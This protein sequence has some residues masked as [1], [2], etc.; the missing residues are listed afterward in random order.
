MPRSATPSPGIGRPLADMREVVDRLDAKLDA[1]AE[2]PRGIA[3]LKREVAAIRRILDDRRRTGGRTGGVSTPATSGRI[4]RYRLCAPR[5]APRRGQGEG[6]MADN[7]PIEWTDASWNPVRARNLETGKVGWFCTHASDG[8]RFCYAETF[9]RRLGTGIDYRAQDRDKVEI[10]LD[11][12]TLQQ[13]LHWR[14]P[15]RIFT[16]SMSDLFGEFIDDEW[17]DRVFAVMAL[18]PQHTFQVLTKRAGRMREYA[19]AHNGMGN[20]PICRAIN[21]IPAGLGN[22]HGALEMPLPN[23]WLGVSVEDQ[24]RADERIPLLLDTPAAK[25]FLSCEPLL[26]PIDLTRLCVLP[27]KPGSIRAGI[28]VDALRNKHCESGLPRGLGGIDWII[29][30]GESGPGARPMDPVWARSLRDQ[31][32][33]AGTAFFMKQ[34]GEWHP[35]A[36]RY[37]DTQGRS[38]PPSM[39]IGKRAAGRLLDGIEHSEFPA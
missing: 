4:A 15:R 12:K 24:P 29:C 28:H 33:A 8:C 14:R 26:G 35:D 39:R 16:L 20:G 1:L 21:A 5:S 25:R 38:P 19:L 31:C 18:C 3:E 9:N 34:W 2:I 27:Q 13:P 32:Q 10:F 7:T 17:I 36:L 6:V 11:E 30:G 22:R 37:T 23:V